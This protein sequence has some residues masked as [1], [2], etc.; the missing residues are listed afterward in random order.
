MI[1]TILTTKAM[2]HFWAG[3]PNLVNLH[4]QSKV[5]VDDILLIGNAKILVTEVILNQKS[6]IHKE[7][8]FYELRYETVS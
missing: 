7:F 1:K 5:L 8:N 6:R 2:C 3:T 4:T